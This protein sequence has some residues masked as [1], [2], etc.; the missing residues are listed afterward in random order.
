MF[1]PLHQVRLFAR[2]AENQRHDRIRANKRPARHEPNHESRNT[3]KGKGHRGE[4]GT[5]FASRS[6]MQSQ[7]GKGKGKGK[8][9]AKGKSKGMLV[10]QG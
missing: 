10:Q 6:F 5:D 3:S 4:K 9:N 8:G 7:K 1:H 2:I